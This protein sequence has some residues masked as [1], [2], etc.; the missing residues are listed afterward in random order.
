M[1]AV[2]LIY[3][4]VARMKFNR[5]CLNYRQF[6]QHK[7]NSV[8]ACASTLSLFFCSL[9]LFF[10]C[11]HTIDWCTAEFIYFFAIKQSIC[12]KNVLR[13]DSELIYLCLI[14]PMHYDI[15]REL[16]F[17][18]ILMPPWEVEISGRQYGCL[19]EKMQM[20]GWLLTVISCSF[21][22]IIV[23][24]LLWFSQVFVRSQLCMKSIHKI[25]KFNV[26]C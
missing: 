3:L 10:M 5:W 19:Q 22:E 20:S 2:E 23:S 15:R 7:M 24:S 11:A 14:F 13:I 25:A 6:Y 18:S 16:N 1:Y 26:I 9:P 21:I 4:F 8:A 17:G 12:L